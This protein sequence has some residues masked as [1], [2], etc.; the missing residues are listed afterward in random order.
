MHARV[1]NIKQHKNEQGN[2]KTVPPTFSHNHHWATSGFLQDLFFQH[3]DRVIMHN[4]TAL[5][6][7]NARLQELTNHKDRIFYSKKFPL[8]PLPHTQK[9]SPATLTESQSTATITTTPS[10][11]PQ[12]KEEQTKLKTNRNW[13][14]QSLSFSPTPEYPPKSTYARIMALHWLPR[15]NHLQRTSIP[16]F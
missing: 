12:E 9:F 13:K 14:G 10:T 1:K 4:T 6:L 15:C 8:P 3:L 2:I 5:E 11:L 7:E 16:L